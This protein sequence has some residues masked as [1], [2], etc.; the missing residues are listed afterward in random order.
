MPASSSR[1]PHELLN[2]NL[3]PLTN[4]FKAEFSG[5]TVD[6][7]SVADLEHVRVRIIDDV[8]SRLIDSAAQ[9][10]ASTGQWR[11]GLQRHR[12][13]IRGR[14]ALRPVEG[15]Q[16]PETAKHEPGKARRA[17]DRPG[18]SAAL[19]GAPMQLHESLNL[20]FRSGIFLSRARHIRTKFPVG[21]IRAN[22]FRLEDIP[23]RHL[24]V[25]HPF[26]SIPSAGPDRIRVPCALRPSGGRR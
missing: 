8:Q 16:H 17:A 26:H 10:F 20:H 11:T 15:S 5:M 2:P 23:C 6:A 7:V 1:P 19:M 3:A 9:F 18:H 24:P 25:S 4:V 21:N 14:P 22:L 13:A 12:I